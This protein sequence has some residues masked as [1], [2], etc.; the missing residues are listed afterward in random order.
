[1]SLLSA[2]LLLLALGNAVATGEFAP[3]RTFRAFDRRNSPGLPQATVIALHQD[4]RG[5]LWI[6]TLDGL[7]SFDGTVIRSLRGVDN[8]PNTGPVYAFAARAGGGFYA[9]GMRGVWENDGQMFH[10][11]PTER[12]VTSVAEGRD[13]SL[14]AVAQDGQV[15]RLTRERRAAGWETIARGP[16]ARGVAVRAVSDGRVFLAEP[17]QIL[18]ADGSSLKPVMSATPEPGS[19]LLVSPTGTVWIGST[20]G[21]VYGWANGEWRRV[22]V[23][24]WD[25][26]FIRVL[27]EDRR[28]RIWVTGNNGRVA[29]GREGEPFTLWGPEN[30]LRTTA[31]I[32][33][34]ADREGTIWFGYNGN[35]V[36][37]W[38]GEGWSHRTRWHEQDPAGNTLAVF[39]VSG[40]TDGGFLAAV[41]NRG[42][43]RWEG[44]T[45]RSYGAAEGL[46]EDVR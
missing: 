19:A 46:T 1:V 43:W 29:F 37:Q 11:L 34:L 18:E 27:A 4:D 22:P 2:P 42:L 14:W 45:M 6:G 9:G 5:V 25:G 23:P 17:S 20:A 39:G 21:A 8:A 44:R 33:L 31:V 30:G 15:L 10:L 16:G 36:Q 40:T 38:L 3:V 24:G 28:G 32:S 26:G 7:A 41:F 12:V 13:G 35:G